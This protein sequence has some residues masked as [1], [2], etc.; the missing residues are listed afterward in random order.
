[1]GALHAGHLSLVDAAKG[2]CGF[3]VVTIFVNP[4]QFGPEEDFARYPR[5]LEADAKALTGRGV[6]VIFAP[7][8]ESMYSAAHA[9]Y[10]EM[11]G[12]ALSLEGQFR[13]GHFRGVAT[14]VLKLFHIVQPDRAYFGRKDYQQSLLMRRM[15]EDL[16]LPIRIQVCPIVREPDGLA[17]SSRN[18]FLSPDERR[19]ALAISQSLR[20]ARQ[21]VAEGTTDAKTVLARMQALLHDAAL[22]VDYIALADPDTLLP[23]DLVARPTVAAIAARVGATRLIDNELIGDE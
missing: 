13:P 15:V 11:D 16:D 5:T 18:V 9:T 8:T 12:P 22:R 17:M 21:L 14:I 4:A 10:V 19:R 20:L 3:T 7:T 2:E 1:M 23:I 6:D